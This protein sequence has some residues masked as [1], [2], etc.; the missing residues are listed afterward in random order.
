MAVV[1]VVEIAI[2]DRRDMSR[3]TAIG[4][5]VGDKGSGRLGLNS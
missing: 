3:D 5:D 1:V 2:S 4:H